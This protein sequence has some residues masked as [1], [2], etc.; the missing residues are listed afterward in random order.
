MV[1]YGRPHLH[2]VQVVPLCSGA[3]SVLLDLVRLE[4]NP[5]RKDLFTASVRLES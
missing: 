2:P 4:E 3:L 1:L 5:H